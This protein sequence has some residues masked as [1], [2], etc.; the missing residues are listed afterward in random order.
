MIIDL[1]SFSSYFGNNSGADTAIWYDNIV[2]AT[3]YIGPVNTTGNDPDWRDP[4]ELPDPTDPAEPVIP[5]KVSPNEV[6]VERGESQQFFTT[7]LPEFEGGESLYVLIGGATW[8]PRDIRVN[9]AVSTANWSFHG[10]EILFNRAHGHNFDLSYFTPDMLLRVY[11]DS[12]Y[13]LEKTQEYMKFMTFN[14]MTI[15]DTY[16]TGRLSS[17]FIVPIDYWDENNTY[18]EVYHSTLAAFYGTTVFSYNNIREHQF[19]IIM[20]NEGG[21]LTI[22]DEPVT[23]LDARLHVAPVA[24]V[25]MIWSVNS[26]KST[27][28]EYGL[29]TVA[30]DEDSDELTVT[31][32]LASDPELFGTATVY[33]TGELKSADKSEL[34]E[35]LFGTVDGA[36]AFID[37]AFAAYPSIV[38]ASAEYAMFFNAV[39][40][41]KEV[42]ESEDATQDEIDAAYATL[43]E[44]FGIFEAWVN[45]L[46]KTLA[47][48]SNAQYVSIIETSKNSRV[49]ELTFTVVLTYLDG[50]VEKVSFTIGLSGNNANLDGK[51]VFETDHGLAG[52]TLVYDIKGNGSNIKD[53][54]IIR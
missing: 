51:Y 28:D 47:N 21:D 17:D 54:R 10:S 13:S 35:L 36:F 14:Y 4:S 26:G 29:L 37:F 33:V 42:F 38:P 1:I 43:L 24:P 40:L 22:G 7:V 46:G 31:A 30:L 8:V 44:A 23:V 45:G 32:A 9:A 25:G 49:W 5:V 18:F 2:V 34:E 50:S 48:I 20:F 27:I 52:Y 53:F 3:E 15:P 41:A 12:P 11:Y 6:S 16:N 19:A 39:T